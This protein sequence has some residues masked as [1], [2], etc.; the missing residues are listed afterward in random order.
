[1]KTYSYWSNGKI[2][3]E[4]SGSILTWDKLYQSWNFDGKRDIIIQN[5]I[6]NAHGV[7]IV[8]KY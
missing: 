8:F 1:M 2:C 3:S 5:T 4:Y 6:G 7:Y